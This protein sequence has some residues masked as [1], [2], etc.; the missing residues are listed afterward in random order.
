MCQY[1]LAKE[2]T[3]SDNTS[4]DDDCTDTNKVSNTVVNAQTAQLVYLMATNPAITINGTLL[5]TL[6]TRIMYVL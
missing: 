4:T 2:V 6:S 3:P 1:L 5:R